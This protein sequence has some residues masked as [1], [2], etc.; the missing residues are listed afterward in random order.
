MADIVKSDNVYQKLSEL[1]CSVDGNLNPIKQN[2][3]NDQKQA[4]DN[5]E[6]TSKSEQSRT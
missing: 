1:F 6:H 2:K 4:T 3:N 5:S